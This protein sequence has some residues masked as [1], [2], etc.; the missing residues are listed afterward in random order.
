MR[1]SSGNLKIC[2]ENIHIMRCTTD[3]WYLLKKTLKNTKPVTCYSN[4]PLFSINITLCHYTSLS[5][6]TVMN[7]ILLTYWCHYKWYSCIDNVK[8]GR[9]LH[10]IGEIQQLNCRYSHLYN[11]PTSDWISLKYVGSNNHLGEMILWLFIAPHVAETGITHTYASIYHNHGVLD[12]LSLSQM[13]GQ[14]KVKHRHHRLS[15]C[16]IVVTQIKNC[17]YGDVSM[18]LICALRIINVTH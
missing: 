18:T 10:A 6:W 15:S 17:R 2:V 1:K 16:F 7:P 5:P 3:Q 11:T 13:K 4:L 14:F 9:S 12:F 8:F